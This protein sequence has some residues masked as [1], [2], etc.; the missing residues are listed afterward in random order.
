[1]SIHRWDVIVVGGGPAGAMAART[2]ARAGLRTLLLEEHP[3]IGAPA[4]CSGKLSLHA[5]REFDLPPSLARTALRAASLYAPDGRVARLRRGEIDSYVVDRDRFDRWLA[6]RAAEAGCEIMLGVRARRAHREGGAVVVEA[7]RRGTTLS[8]RAAV[9]I[10]AEGARTLLPASLGIT[11]RRT[12]IHGLQYEMDGLRLESDDGPELY[13]GRDWAPGFFA[14]IMPL[15]ASAGRVGLCIDPRLTRRPP[16]YYLERL[17]A[18]HP[19]TARRVRGAR[20]VRRLVGRIPV[21]GSRAPSYAPG[22]LVAGDA[23]GQ[24]KAT[25]GGGIY[26]SLAAGRMAAEAGVAM[27]AG[28]REAGPRYEEVWKRRFGR[29]LTFTTAVRKML[30]ALPDPDLSRL[31]GA[32]GANPLLQRAIEE[33][34]DTQYQSRLLRPVLGQALRSW[35]GIRLAPAVLRAL[36]RGLLAADGEEPT[37]SGSIVTDKV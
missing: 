33:H 17:I 19:V 29:E 25:S 14:W 34:G 11:P 2:A 6:D 30:N 27:A 24:V 26:F 28:D 7:E 3:E 8:L 31:I 32:I 37:A 20:L 23:A 5:F 9:V 12:L 35:R 22:F 18:E 15:G 10:D 36:I 1:M 4:H 16:V 21:L 13:F